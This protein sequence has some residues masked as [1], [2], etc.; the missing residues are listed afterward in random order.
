MSGTVLSQMSQSQTQRMLSQELGF[1]T[2][3]VMDTH[4][5][6]QPDP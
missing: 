1:P 3:R 2:G 5:G 4:G 6:V